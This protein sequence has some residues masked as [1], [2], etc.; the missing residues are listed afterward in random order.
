MNYSEFKGKKLSLLGFGGMRFPTNADGS[1][2]YPKAE[3]MVD[4]A[5]KSGVN[6]FDT[7]Y[8]YHDG[9]SE[10]FFG[11][12]LKKYPRDSYY[13][14]N[15]MPAWFCKTKQD[16]E[17]LFEEQLKRCDETYF[18]FYLLH[19]ITKGNYAISEQ[20]DIVEFLKKKKAEGYIKHLG[21]SFHGDVPLMQE[22]LDKYGDVFEFCQLQLNYYDWDKIS[23]GKLYEM[24]TAK[25]LPVVVMEPVRGGLLA[26][27]NAN[28]E[29]V[30]HKHNKD[31]STASWA[32][33]F[34]GDLD[35]VMVVLSGMTTMEQTVDNIKN[36]SMPKL[37]E[38][39]HSAIQKALKIFLERTTIPCTG[40]RY[41][42]PCPMGINIPDIFK[43]YINMTTLGGSWADYLNAYHAQDKT[44]KDC[45]HCNTCMSHCPQGLNI[46]E[47]LEA[48]ERALPY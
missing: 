22:V 33:R 11:K 23:A 35:N 37:T 4:V 27:L 44:F 10:V 15:K 7:A 9:A 31:M 40:C 30:L 12:V 34:V 3:A 14:T 16:V 36:M 20:L 45:V 28:A 2:D 1:I 43:A 26:K 18:D 42:M 32:V 24:A 39:D 29:E 25:G 5:Y 13:L 48:T 21:F 46:P 47:L 19:S 6:Y 17:A 41:C 8:M 38:A